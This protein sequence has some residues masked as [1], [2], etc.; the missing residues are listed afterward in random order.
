MAGRLVID[1]VLVYAVVLQVHVVGV[2]V[3]VLIVITLSDEREDDLV[4]HFVPELD[5]FVDL[6]L[7]L[8]ISRDEQIPLL[9]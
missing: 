9:I 5:V 7:E 8:L 3:H 1:L 6:P 4:H 2:R